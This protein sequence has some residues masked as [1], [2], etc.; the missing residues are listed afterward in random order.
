MFG[1]RDLWQ[2]GRSPVFHSLRVRSWHR[3]LLAMLASHDCTSAILRIVMVIRMLSGRTL[4]L[5]HLWMFVVQQTVT[6]NGA[7]TT[8]CSITVDALMVSL[9]SSYQLPWRNLHWWEQT[10]KTSAVMMISRVEISPCQVEQNL[11]CF[12]TRVMPPYSLHG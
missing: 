5:S 10:Q 1:E 2:D 11:P 7:R 12:R 8:M 6:A 4:D 9:G 3:L